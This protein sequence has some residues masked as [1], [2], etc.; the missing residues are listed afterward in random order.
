MPEL[1]DLVAWGTG[2]LRHAD[3]PSPDADV[4]ILLAHIL[5]C[6]PSQLFDKQS[7]SSEQA[8]DFERLV[9]QREHRIPVQHLTH[10]AYF[11]HLTL[12]V[13][14]G[15]FIPRPET[16]LLAQAGIDYLNECSTPRVAVEL[17]AGSGAMTLALATE[18]Q[19]VSITAVEISSEAIAWLQRN[20]ERHNQ[21]A[22]DNGSTVTIV[23]ADATQVDV[24]SQLTGHVDAIV[25]NPPY[26]PDGMI[27]R[28]PEVREHDPHVA[29]F[30]GPDGL[31]IVREILP[32][33]HRILKAG[34]FLGI[35]H[36][37]VQGESL[38]SLLA[39]TGHWVQIQDHCD[40]NQRPRFT[41]AIK[42]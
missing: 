19:G 33:A 11:R 10:V 6:E 18:V 42:A 39:T 13:G 37:D 34:G 29:L 30:G 1:S 21:L 16:E 2:K 17:C 12:D 26:I 22:D 31:D 7:I 27:P 36:A 38:P 14:P 41:T 20:V 25:C 8:S 28:E 5:K 15:V 3:V 32:V 23:H 35:E 4:R 9:A 40:Y 24:L